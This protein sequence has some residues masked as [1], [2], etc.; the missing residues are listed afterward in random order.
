MNVLVG[1]LSLNYAFV[2]PEIYYRCM[3]WYTEFFRCILTFRSVKQKPVTRY[4]VREQIDY[5]WHDKKGR[6]KYFK[7]DEKSLTSL[8][9]NMEEN[10]SFKMHYNGV[11]YLFLI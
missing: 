8:S 1:Y 11:F 9:R 6:R 4:L 10:E 2:F 7:S 5:P 3:K